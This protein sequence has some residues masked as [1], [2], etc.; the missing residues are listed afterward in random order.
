MADL[1]D[2]TVTFILGGAYKV[3][4]KVETLICA[5]ECSNLTNA[6]MFK[7]FDQHK[8]KADNPDVEV[9][10]DRDPASFL[11]VLN[12]LRILR[13]QKQNGPDCVVEM[14]PFNSLME[15]QNF[16]NEINFWKIPPPENMAY[17][18]AKNGVQLIPK[19][20]PTTSRQS[21]LERHGGQPEPVPSQPEL[22]NITIT[23]RLKE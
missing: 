21:H 8:T 4:T 18:L 20:S 10:I 14:P 2:I 23:D 22:V 9:H 5:G 19:P 15:Q 16:I 12:Y 3:T 13:H 7:L 17:S 1:S 11:S 6:W